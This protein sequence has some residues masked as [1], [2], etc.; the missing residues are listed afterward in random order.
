MA[1]TSRYRIVVLFCLL[2]SQ[3]TAQ[4][5]TSQ[6][7]NYLNV[8][9][10]QHLLISSDSNYDF[11]SQ[12][13]SRVSGIQHVYFIQ[14]VNGLPISG[15]ESSIHLKHNKR[16]AANARFVKDAKSKLGGTAPSI[17]ALDA[18][19]SALNSLNYT[20]SEPLRILTESA[21]EE[22]TTVISNGGVFGD[23]INASLKYKMIDTDRIDL[24]WNFTLNDEAKGHYWEVSVNAVSGEMT[25]VKDKLLHCYTH[26]EEG[27]KE[28][29]N[30]NFNPYPP[31]EE[32]GSNTNCFG[33]YSAFIWPVENPYYGDRS[34]AFNPVGNIASPYGWHD[35][36]GVEGPDDTRTWG[37]N[38]LVSTT[39]G[40]MANGGLELD[41]TNFPLSLNFNVNNRSEAAA[42]TNTFV[43]LN[44]LHDLLYIY[45][46]DE[47]AGNFQFNNYERG[48]LENDLMRVNAQRT[49][50]CGSSYQPVN[51]GEIGVLTLGVCGNKD[52]SLD[53]D[54]LI[55]E[56][57]HGL[58]TRLI[59]GPNYSACYSNL[60][61]LLEGISDWYAK[62]ITIKQGDR[63]S[64]PTG[65]GNFI[66]NQGPEGKGTNRN[67]Y[68]TN[69]SINPT[70]YNSIVVENDVHPI[71]AVWGNI[72]WEVTWQ[73]IDKHGFDP[74]LTN[75]TGTAADAGNIRAL[76]IVTEA[77][78]LMPCEP[79]FVQ[80]RDAILLANK[81]IYGGES[82]C[83]L[84]D[85]FA[86]RGLGLFAVQGSSTSVDDNTEDFTTAPRE[87]QFELNETLCDNVGF[88][89]HI[90]GLPFGGIYSGEGVSDN[91]D[92]YSFFIDTDLLEEG[93]YEVHYTIQGSPDCYLES[94]AVGY[95]EIKEDDEPPVPLCEGHRFVQTYDISHEY[96]LWDYT[97]GVSF[98]DNC[99]AEV[100][101]TQEPPPLTPLNPGIHDL[102]FKFEDLAGN[103]AYCNASV[104]IEVRDELSAGEAYEVI[105]IPNPSAGRVYIENLSSDKIISITI[106]DVLGRTTKTYNL[107]KTERETELNIES[108]VKGVYFMRFEFKRA[109]LVK[110]LVKE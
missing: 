58:E 94:T 82:D 105:M 9:Q 102:K 40:Y 101:I 91:G 42:T 30:Y 103:V 84:W 55:H 56:Y 11:S 13:T 52:A 60:E 6:I 36:N 85:A 28:V 1:A 83:F 45:G 39:Q 110:Q 37:N 74:D 20:V 16:V 54:V 88:V 18:V 17:S 38:V 107:E 87:A 78:K 44:Q 7:D 2:V 26:N 92:G 67:Y 21:S 32:V 49:G 14:M 62:V 59:G 89:Y 104:S 46:F 100:V 10:Q 64:D 90:G 29:L 76:A 66:L 24:I 33:C 57:T 95:F 34:I 93:T 106:L 3:I 65:F 72:L 97:S 25:T 31:I 75:F 81:N 41:F 19:G 8:L 71:G 4:S 69:M 98:T 22:R 86:K 12:H 27:H 53:S 5:V 108:L 43:V 35:L 63:G 80:G 51:D 99:N 73:L 23:A 47:E 109:E 50:R 70:T 79:G 61:N 68:S 96:L 77:H 48:G 15:T